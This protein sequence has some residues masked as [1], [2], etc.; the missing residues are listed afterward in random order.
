M[1][2]LTDASA[3]HLGLS[4]GIPVGAGTVDAYGSVI[5]AGLVD[6]GDAIDAGGTSGGFGVIWDG[7]IAMGAAL[8]S[9][10]PLPGRGLYGG[11]MSS[12]A[13]AFDW[14][15]DS[16]LAGTASVDEPLAEA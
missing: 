12:T 1:G 13:K 16:I 2:T 8:A 14:L 3:R 15:R 10:A 5:G 7:P 4:P 11:G 9:A 6:P